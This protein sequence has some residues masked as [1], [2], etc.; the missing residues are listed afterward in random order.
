MNIED[1]TDT[2]EGE[3]IDKRP[4]GRPISAPTTKVYF[5]LT[6][7]V[8]ASVDAAAQTNG[9][10]RTQYLRMQITRMHGGGGDAG[11]H[12]NGGAET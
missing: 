5:R 2:N 11:V 3:M 8:L 10:S 7:E 12:G 6:D 9:L 1:A 4:V